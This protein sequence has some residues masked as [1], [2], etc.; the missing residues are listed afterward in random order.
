M[1]HEIEPRKFHVE[2]MN[3]APQARDTV[4]VFSGSGVIGDAAGGE[5]TF[6]RFEEISGV[7]ADELRYLFSIDEDRFFMAESGGGREISAPDKYAMLDNG[8]FRVNKPRHLAFAAVTAQQLFE[9]YASHRYCG[10]CGAENGHSDKERSIVCPACGLVVYPKIS[11]VV[12]V[13]VTNGDNLLV[14]RY[15]DRPFRMYALVAGFGEIGEAHED[16]VRREVFEETGV[17]VKNIRYYKSQPWGFSSSLL[18]G[19][20]CDLDGDP[21]ITVDGEELSEA[22][23]LPRGEIPPSSSDVALTAEMM[24]VFRLGLQ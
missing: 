16:T 14:T 2:Y 12:I 23:W 19:F 7:G 10:R 18:S 13:A 6:P 3:T 21:A 20:F 8:A 24:E 22:I 15:K 4:F 1:I 5:L 9:W 11:P 17:R